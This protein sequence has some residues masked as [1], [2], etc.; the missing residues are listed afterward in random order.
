VVTLVASPAGLA[1]GGTFV[2]WLA[3][4]HKDAN[5]RAACLFFAGTTISY[6]AATIMPSAWWALTGY[7]V[8]RVFS[9]AGAVPQNAAIQRVAPNSMR[10]QV[11]AF[12]LFMFTFFGAMGS[13]VIGLIAQYVVGDPA[14]LWLA[15]LITSATI[16]PLATFFMFRA[17]RPYGEEVSRLEA[18]G[19]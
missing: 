1:L 18:L 17:I 19:Q 8:A 4:R 11:T 12:Y 10:G 14:R 2:E 3:K 6:V 15:L 5:V 7:G 16:L 9:M 13:F